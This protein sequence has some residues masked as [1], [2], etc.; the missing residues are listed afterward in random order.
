MKMVQAVWNGACINVVVLS[1]AGVCM[2]HVCTFDHGELRCIHL[3]LAFTMKQ[4]YNG[5]QQ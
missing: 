3:P 5:V 4:P 1:R 2:V